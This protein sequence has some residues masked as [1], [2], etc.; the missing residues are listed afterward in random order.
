MNATRASLDAL[1]ANLRGDLAHAEQHVRDLGRWREHAPV[2]YEAFAAALLLH[3]VYSAIEAMLERALKTFDGGLPVGDSSHI[4]LLERASAEVPGVRP[5][6]LPNLTAVDELRRFRHRLRKR[7]DVDLEP[8]RLQ[9]I[10][11]TALTGLAGHQS[12]TERVCRLRR[13]LCSR[14]I[15]KS[16]RCE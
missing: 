14:S 12:G 16:F 8:A 2:G 10:I 5:L 11:Q 4:E 13:R 3:H 1:L 9:P 15:L 6:I 7:Y